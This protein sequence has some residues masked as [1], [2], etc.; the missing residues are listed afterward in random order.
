MLNEN[1]EIIFDSAGY[2]VLLIV[3]ENALQRVYIEFFGIL[4]ICA[5]NSIA[6]R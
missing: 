5:E 4:V 6:E 1:Q 2:I 3:E